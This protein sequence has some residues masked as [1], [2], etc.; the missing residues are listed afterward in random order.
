MLAPFARPGVRNL[1][2]RTNS[3]WSGPFPPPPPPPAT[4]RG[5]CSR[6]SQVLWACPTSRRRT[7]PSCSLDSRRGPW[8]HFPGPAGGISRFLLARLACVRGVFDHAG[9][10]RHLRWRGGPCCFPL[11]RVRQRPGLGFS[12]LNSPAHMPPVNASRTPYGRLAHDS[13]LSGSLLLSH[14][15]LAPPVSRQ[16]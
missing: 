8:R 3:P 10:N 11:M 16:F 6:A 7:S 1:F 12:R 14:R 15:G 13:G 4:R 9:P 2:A 5:F